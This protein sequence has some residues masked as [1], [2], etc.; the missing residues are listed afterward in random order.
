MDWQPRELLVGIPMK[1][2]E[3]LD[4]EVKPDEIYQALLD[5]YGGDS[6]PYRLMDYDLLTGRNEDQRLSKVKYRI[7]Y[8]PLMVKLRSYRSLR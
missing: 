6:G 1:L 4:R 5:T 8:S 2:T 7:M 3:R